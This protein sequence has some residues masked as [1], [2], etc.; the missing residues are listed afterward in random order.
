MPRTDSIARLIAACLGIVALAVAAT[1]LSR[2][3]GTGVSEGGGGDSP[4]PQPKTPEPTTTVDVPGFL[5]YLVPVLAALAVVLLIAYG[6]AHFRHAVKYF[7]IGV[8]VGA[9]VLLLAWLLLQLDLFGE[10]FGFGTGGGEG[11]GSGSGGVG[12]DGESADPTIPS[13]AVLLFL[14]VG[15]VALVGVTTMYLRREDDPPDPATPT[16]SDDLDEVGAVASRAADRIERTEH[17]ETDNEVY[18]AWAEMTDYLDVERPESSTPGEFERAAIEAGMAREDVDELTRLFESVRYG[19]AE[20]TD[21]RETQ[22]VTVLRRIEAEYD[23]RTPR[24][25]AEGRRFESA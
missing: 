19:P 23:D 18:R 17:A 1:T 7:A 12:V 9:G 21:E 15:F 14:G 22:A 4:L 3:S 11:F 24:S 6:I 16:R 8:A 5:E 2:R 10:A 25:D 13:V 20:T